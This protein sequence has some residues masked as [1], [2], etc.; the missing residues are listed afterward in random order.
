MDFD[1]TSLYQ[2]AMWDENSV[3]S[4][5]EIGFVFRLHMNDIFVEAFK[6]QTF[7][8]KSDGSAL[9]KIE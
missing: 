2:P 9:L 5:I 7:S 4:R 1:C 8:Q 6:S 3:Y